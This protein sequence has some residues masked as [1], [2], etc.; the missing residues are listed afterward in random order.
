[1]LE[2]E[3]I[4]ESGRFSKPRGRATLRC[5][6][7][8]CGR[9]LQ[10][11]VLRGGL[12]RR[13]RPESL[14]SPRDEE[15]RLSPTG[16][17]KDLNPRFGR[18]ARLRPAQSGVQRGNRKR[19]RVCVQ[20]G[21]CQGLVRILQIRKRQR[22]SLGR[23]DAGS[24]RQSTERNTAMVKEA[25]VETATD[26]G[27]RL[28][29]ELD[30]SQFPVESMFWVQLPDMGRWRLVIGSPLV[31]GQGPRPAYDR[32]GALLRQSG[33]GLEPAGRFGLRSRLGRACIVAVNGR[34]VGPR[35]C[36]ALLAVIRR[37]RS[38]PLD[39]GCHFCG[40]KLRPDPG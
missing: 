5:A 33:R 36:R 30:R 26:E 16:N 19:F 12:R 7:A 9:P 40:R 39:G 22:S 13:M 3:P 28:L 25:L 38:V 27:A 8:A 14:Y 32:L 11:C 24:N 21:D 23:N 17:Q 4:S 20:L 29:S 34:N 15:R 31:R 35:G 37:R 6:G 18:P 10:L 2:V 1:M